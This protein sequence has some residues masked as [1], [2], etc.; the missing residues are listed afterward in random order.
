MH[1]VLQAVLE[2]DRHG[3]V[4]GRVALHA[5]LGAALDDAERAAA[6]GRRRP[7]SPLPELLQRHRRRVLLGQLAGLVEDDRARRAANGRRVDLLE[8]EF[9]TVAAPVTVVLPGGRAIGLRGQLDRLDRRGDGSPVVV[10]YKRTGKVDNAHVLGGRGRLQVAMYA[11]AARQMFRV[12]DV[13]AE[14]VSITEGK[15]HTVEAATMA[16]AEQLVEL[17]VEAIEAG[18]FWPP[19]HPPRAPGMRS[20]AVCDPYGLFDRVLAARAGGAGS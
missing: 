12:T 18:R 5:A 14:L 13:A 19:Q 3:V 4:A 6:A 17:I 9:G 10:D 7:S 2:A 1:H 8:H 20:C 16:D 15:V 11:A